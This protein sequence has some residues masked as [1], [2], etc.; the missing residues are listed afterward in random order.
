MHPMPIPR[1]LVVAGKLVSNVH[2]VDLVAR[3]RGLPFIVEAVA[4]NAVEV[5]EE[6]TLGLRPAP[7]GAVHNHEGRV[8]HH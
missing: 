6:L 8:G 7:H 2:A 4:V 3:A 5:R 1:V